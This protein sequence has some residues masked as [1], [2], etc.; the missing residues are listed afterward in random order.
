MRHL[1]PYGYIDQNQYLPSSSVDLSDIHKVNAKQDIE[2]E[3][4]SSKTQS[5][6]SVEMIN[7][8]SGDVKT[9]F[10]KQDAMNKLFANTI[11]TTNANVKSL[12]SAQTVMTSSINKLIDAQDTIDD[13]INAL[14]NDVKDL[15]K[16]VSASTSG[17]SQYIK[18]IDFH[19]SRVDVDLQVLGAEVGNKLSRIDADAL[20]AHKDDVYTKA[21][22]YTKEEVDTLVGSSISDA[23]TKTWTNENF[24]NKTESDERFLKKVDIAEVEK[25][26]EKHVEE[27]VQESLDAIKMSLQTCQTRIDTFNKK[28]E[29]L[30]DNILKRITLIESKTNAFMVDSNNKIH[31]TVKDQDVCLNTLLEK[32]LD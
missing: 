32:L 12:T 11:N 9:A 20:Y 8:L 30:A 17:I 22:T 28:V 10:A 19:L 5:M 6:V 15:Q 14:E 29:D 16:T 23:A 13:K 7:A 31:L 2:I 1:E 27:N 26:I 3:E 25:T 24:Y 4:I 18:E 21:E